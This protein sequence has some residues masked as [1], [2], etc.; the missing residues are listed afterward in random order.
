[1]IALALEAKEGH[2]MDIID[3]PGAY[4][5]TYMDKHGK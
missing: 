3:I 1:M 5:H 4:L 2:D